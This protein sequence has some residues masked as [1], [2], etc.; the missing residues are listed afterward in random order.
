[1]IREDRGLEVKNPA[2][3]GKLRNICLKLVID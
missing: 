3:G 2:T 1:M